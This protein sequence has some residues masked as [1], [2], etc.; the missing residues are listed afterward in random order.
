MGRPLAGLAREHQDGRLTSPGDVGTA[1]PPIPPDG[2][3]VVIR[4]RSG[5]AD[6]LAAVPALRAL[7]RHR[8]GA[9]VTV[10]TGRLA[11]PHWQR[12]ATLVDEVIPFPG[13]P[14]VAGRRT[15][16]TRMPSFL[17]GMQA[18]RFDLALQLHDDGRLLN[19]FVALLGARRSAGYHPSG[20]SPPDART[21]L[22]WRAGESDVRRGLRLMARLGW[23]DDD[24][25]LE[26]PVA[27][28]VL[29][30]DGLVRSVFPSVRHTEDRVPAALIHP[31][32]ARPGGWP[33][34]RF[35]RAADGFAATGMR[36][37]LTGMAQDRA[38]TSGVLRATAAPTTDLVGRTT[39][40]DL[41]EL[42][43]RAAVV[44]TADPGAACLAAALRVPS[45]VVC[46][47]S[48]AARWAFLDRRL[49]RV[50]SGSAEEAIAQARRVMRS[51]AHATA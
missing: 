47:R 28:D 16:V 11:V 46:G 35:A 29:Q 33:A 5:L 20:E 25:S 39:L 7:R 15:D 49:H 23:H 1:D 38:V 4:P 3:V 51:P 12:F 18:R 37:V 50:V 36:L 43:R 21:W 27:R 9:A 41:A 6:V 44:L 32:T 24:E 8:P 48:E 17:A 10:I 34:S 31:G 26:F 19:T 45:V 13:W 30:Q 22:P 40:D 14:G 2:R 42:M